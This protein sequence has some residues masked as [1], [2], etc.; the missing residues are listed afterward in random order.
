MRS[1]DDWSRWG[2]VV[3]AVLA[4]VAALSLVMPRLLG[5]AAGPEVEIITALK[6]T[7]KDGMELAIPGVGTPLRSKG[8]H[9]ARITVNVEPGGKRAVAWATLDFTGRLERTEVS[10]LGVER[11]P[12][13][14]RG[15]EWMPEGL[16]APRLA[17]VVRTLEARRR[18]LEAGEGKAL[19]ALRAPDA[20][21]DGGGG[22]EAAEVGKVLE[23]RR[24]RYRA[25]AWFLRLERDEAV[26]SETWRLEGDLPSRPVDERGQRRLSLIRSG[27]EFLFSAGLM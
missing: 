24:R 13:V 16:A 23:V 18:A 15:R 12:F 10:S 3:I 9:F 6:A 22:E 26:A 8:H 7:E 19:E 2:G 1:A 25:E 21:G 20:R 5:V 11:V 14:R 17:A 4:A 27:E